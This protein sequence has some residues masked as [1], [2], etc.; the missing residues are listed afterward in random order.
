MA[1]SRHSE[2]S[3]RG[4]RA[5]RSKVVSYKEPSSDD[6]FDDS[7]D[8]DDHGHSNGPTRRSSNLNA[9]QTTRA[10]RSVR[11]PAPQPQQTSSRRGGRDQRA[12]TRDNAISSTKGSSPR[13]AESHSKHGGHSKAFSIT[14]Q[15]H[16]GPIPPWQTLPYQI[17]VQIFQ[18]ASYPLYN[19]RFHPTSSIKWLLD[20]ARLCK[21]FAE[22]ALTALYR[23]P[24]LLPSDRPHGLLKLLSESPDIHSFNY[25]VKIKRLEV[26]VYQTLAYTT[27]GLG[28]VDLGA[29]IRHTPQLIDLELFHI[30][31]RPPY[32]DLG[33]ERGLKWLYP[34]SLF[35]ALDEC[36]R[37][38]VVWRWNA[39]M[40]GPKQAL[41]NLKSIH[42]TVPFRTIRDLAFVNYNSSKRRPKDAPN[43]PDEAVLADA[44]SVLPNLRCLHFEISS[45]VNGN[46]LPLL[47]VNLSHLSFV[48]CTSLTSDDLQPFLISHG[49]HLK[50]LILDHNQ[51]L[52]LAF[53]PTLAYSCPQLEI[54]KMDLTF[55]SSHSFYHDSEPLYATLLDQAEIPTWPKTLRCIELIQLRNWTAGSAETFFQSLLDSA[56][57]LPDLRR[58][59]LKVILQ[60]GWRDRARFRDRWIGKLKRAFLRQ[61]DPPDPNLRS[62]R[63]FKKWKEGQR[64]FD[65]HG[66]TLF[67][68]S[69]TPH[70]GA[71]PE[72]DSDAPLLLR[73]KST[74]IA[75]QNEAAAVEL[76]QGDRP[77]R[78]KRKLHHESDS[79]DDDDFGSDLSNS[80]SDSDVA[81]KG[82]SHVQ[83]MCEVVDI[84]IDNLRPAEAQFNENDFLD[85]EASG[86]EEWDGTDRVPGDERY[87]W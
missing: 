86:D 59:V 38:L 34:D 13:K 65:H 12:N 16:D 17:L 37:S 74:R 24:P 80:E 21:A 33:T 77:R 5:S 23:S 67:G 7:D 53:L 40:T 48:K 10:T 83:G 27:P 63:T 54:L 31:D 2:T 18:C 9:R 76:S 28:H 19:D 26:E 70:N 60:I 75:Q 46:L 62:L 64:S 1:P 82:E 36:Q 71:K 51:S 69:E 57:E 25:N 41:P 52:D 22:P 55:Y 47:P 78:K 58:L 6:D 72:S 35:S 14:K 45:I 68:Q 39:R 8:F 32:R 3:T 30:S 43:D 56:A 87:A 29:L 20:T 73:R 15:E 81:A 42:Q 11:A 85:S 49:H 4:R 66:Q 44:L 84:R 79:S 50:E 61:S